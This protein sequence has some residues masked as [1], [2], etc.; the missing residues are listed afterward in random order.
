MKILHHLN[1]RHHPHHAVTGTSR[2]RTPPPLNGERAGVRGENAFQHTHSDR[3][4]TLIECLVYI[5]LV[6]VVLG[7][8]TVAFYRCFDNM[9]ALRRNSDDIA[10][11]LHVGELWRDD[12]RAATKPV[13]FETSDQLLLIPHRNGAVAYKFAGNQVSRRTGT[14]APW[15]VLLPKVENSQMQADTHAPVTAWRWELELKTLRKPAVMRP[16]FT[17]TAVPGATTTP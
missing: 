9:K 5:G 3:A 12:I 15:V 10:Q 7:L 1:A 14:N 4:F 11:A 6:F 8:G 13:Q 16:L 17:F 2:V